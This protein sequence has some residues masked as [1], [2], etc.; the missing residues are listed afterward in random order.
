MRQIVSQ[1]GWRGVILSNVVHSCGFVQKL[2]WYSPIR[3]MVQLAQQ[4]NTFDWTLSLA[5]HSKNLSVYGSIHLL[6]PYLTGPTLE[7]LS[8]LDC[9]R[10]VECGM[11]AAIQVQVFA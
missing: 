10:G 9:K 2:M 4:F 8:G 7:P 6:V 3:I 5:L 11:R 1:H